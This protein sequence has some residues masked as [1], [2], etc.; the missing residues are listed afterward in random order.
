MGNCIPKCIFCN[1]ISTDDI[2]IAHIHHKGKYGNKY[3]CSVCLENKFLEKYKKT[4]T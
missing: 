3:I 2:Y 1:N 4:Y